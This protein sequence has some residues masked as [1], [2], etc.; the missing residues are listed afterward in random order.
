MYV[1]SLVLTV[2]DQVGLTCSVD[3]GTQQFTA[4]GLQFKDCKTAAI[5][6]QW[7]WGWVGKLAQLKRLKLIF[8]YRSGKESA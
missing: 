6:S 5:Q 3:G 7:D 8:I 1:V 4:L 2:R